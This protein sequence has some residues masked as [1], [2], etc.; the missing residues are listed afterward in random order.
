MAF[1]SSREPTL[2]IRHACPVCRVP[3]SQR[4]V[5]G[6]G[7]RHLNSSSLSSSSLM[8]CCSVRSVRLPPIYECASLTESFPLSTLTLLYLCALF[9]LCSALCLCPSSCSLSLCLSL[10][11]RVS[12]GAGS[13]ALPCMDIA[14]PPRG[15]LFSLSINSFL[16][17]SGWSYLLHNQGRPEL[18][19][20][21]ARKSL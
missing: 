7:T 9:L 8:P 14:L 2:S 1:P 16:S 15:P 10:S 21:N 19:A 4:A 6:R 11:F 17:P 12:P 20:M 5:R 3:E 18:A 13:G